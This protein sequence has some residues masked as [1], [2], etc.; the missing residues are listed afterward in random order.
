MQKKKK[1]SMQRIK[2]RYPLMIPILL[3]YYSTFSRHVFFSS[4]ALTNM[5][6]IS[7]RSFEENLGDPDVYTIA[8]WGK[9]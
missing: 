2:L 6:E 9:N 7:T 4:I 1:T 8:L 3:M 5:Q